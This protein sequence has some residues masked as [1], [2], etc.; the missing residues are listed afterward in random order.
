MDAKSETT[1]SKGDMKKEPFSRYKPRPNN[2]F[3]NF[4]IPKRDVETAFIKDMY[5]E[6]KNFKE[7]FRQA[8]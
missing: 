1:K 8:I 5:Y 2:P 3:R 7:K 4:K 6:N